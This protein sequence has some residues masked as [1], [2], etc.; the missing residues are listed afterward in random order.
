MIG[1]SEIAFTIAI[2]TVGLLFYLIYSIIF[3]KPEEVN[4]VKEL[5]GKLICI[6]M[7]KVAYSYSFK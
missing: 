2:A 7:S 3:K 5:K 4:S 1:L 6:L